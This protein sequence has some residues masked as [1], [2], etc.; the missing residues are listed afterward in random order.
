[1]SAENQEKIYLLGWKA[2]DAERFLKERGERVCVRI[3]VPTVR[4][5]VEGSLRVIKQ[6]VRDGAWVLTA[7]RVTD[8]YDV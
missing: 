2:F 4:E 6:E 1:M 5:T 7:C 3:T 8:P